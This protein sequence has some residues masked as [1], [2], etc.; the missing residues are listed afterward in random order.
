M[1]VCMIVRVDGRGQP[2]V[3]DPQVLDK[4][5]VEMLTE[6]GSSLMGL[7][8][9]SDDG[10]HVWL[11]VDRLRLLASTSEVGRDW[12]REFDAMVAFADSKGWLDARRR[13]RAHIE[14]P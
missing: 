5:H 13:I 4:L 2:T 14:R 9:L 8:E 1:L 11:D 10:E 6:D 12:D 7:G 3:I